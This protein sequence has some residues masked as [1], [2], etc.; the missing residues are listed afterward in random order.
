MR[1]IDLH[2]D[3][4]RTITETG[5][6]TASRSF[7]FD[8]IVFATGFDAMTGPIVA[9]DVQ[10]RAGQTGIDPQRGPHQSSPAVTRRSQAPAA[11]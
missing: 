8:A 10:G 7:T 2:R 1:L 4:I 5:I 3:P 6:T 11:G 9:V